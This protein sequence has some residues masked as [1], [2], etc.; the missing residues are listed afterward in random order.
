MTGQVTPGDNRW[1]SM[2]IK[3]LR[4]KAGADGDESKRRTTGQNTMAS[5]AEQGMGWKLN[6]IWDSHSS[7]QLGLTGLC[8]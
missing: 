4:Q 1:V 7:L 8:M 5:P 2:R 3:C 6:G